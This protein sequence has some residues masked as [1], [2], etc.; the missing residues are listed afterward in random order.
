LDPSQTTINHYKTVAGMKKIIKLLFVAVTT[1]LLCSFSPPE[2]ESAVYKVARLKRPMKI[3]AN[4]NKREWKKVKEFEITNYMGKV[5]AFKPVTKVKM[6]YDNENVYVI[7]H[8]D[9]RFVRLRSKGFNSKVFE[10]ACVEFFFSPDSS[11]PLAYFNLETN[12]GGTALMGYHEQGKVVDY[13]PPSDIK[14][15]IAHTMP[16]NLD[17]EIKEPVSWTLEYRLPISTLKKYSNVT[18]PAKGVEWKAN[19]FK[20]SSKN[21]NEHYI[22][23]SFVNNR[24]PQFHLPQFFG[25][26]KFK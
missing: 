4:W 12:A 16:Q 3:D 9:D 10:D 5:P 18:N 8:V 17:E 14:L 1:T 23:W 6:M 20:T 21:S 2:T 19:F 7:F 22:T 24:T 26:L 15:E 11:K 25:T 13:L